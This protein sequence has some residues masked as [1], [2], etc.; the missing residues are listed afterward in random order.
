MK[1][2]I[3]PSCIDAA[4]SDA[5]DYGLRVLMH[6]ASPNTS[7]QILV[8]DKG[9][10]LDSY[11]KAILNDPNEFTSTWLN[12]IA[13]NS[14]IK[15]KTVKVAHSPTNNLNIN[16]LANSYTGG[17]KVLLA[18]DYSLAK[19]YTPTLEEYAIEIKDKEDS[20]QYLSSSVLPTHSCIL[21]KIIDK[22]CAMMRKK[23]SIKLEDFHNDEL[24]VG[25]EDLGFN[26]DEQSRSGITKSKQNPGSLDILIKKNHSNRPIAIVEA[27]RESS[28]GARN[29]NI[30]EHL[31]KLLNDYDFIGLETNYLITYCE[32]KDFGKFWSNYLSY[33]SKINDHS[34]FSS[35]IPQL[36][37]VD[38]KSD[39]VDYA[40]LRIGKGIYRRNGRD[41]Q[42]YHIVSN[43][44]VPTQ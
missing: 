13:N 38:T 35:N 24:V 1:L 42:V 8:D 18:Q 15:L 10:I 14:H 16:V 37:F 20:I 21:S 29:N 25:L 5:Y 17:Q 32:A 40:D 2:S 26:V 31:D 36:S 41:V 22:L 6:I 34:K 43:M 12:A 19:Q 30:A 44:Y 33:M 23:R 3:C 9:E 4:S 27:L 7:F 28:C 39:I 11:R